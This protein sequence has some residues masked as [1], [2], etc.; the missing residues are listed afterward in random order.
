MPV[1]RRPDRK[2]LLAY[3]SGEIQAS[4]SIDKS[5]PLEIS[6][7][8][9][10]QGR[11]DTQLLR[12]SSPSPVLTDILPMNLDCLATT[13]TLP[14]PVFQKT[15]FFGG[16]AAG[17]G[18]FDVPEAFLH[19]TSCIRTLKVTSSSDPDCGNLSLALILT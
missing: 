4:G 18:V 8:R 10:T 3:L 12:L 7:Q 9:P 11:C 2:D 1:V 15:V 17:T 19:P 5:A 13:R 6:L 16:G 14:S